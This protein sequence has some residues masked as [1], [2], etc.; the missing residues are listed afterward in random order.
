MDAL[1]SSLISSCGMNCGICY[2]Y[3]REKNKCQ[4]CRFPDPHKPIT[5]VKCKIKNCEGIKYSKRTFCFECN[6]FPCDVLKHLDKRYRTKYNMSMI[7]NLENI[8]NLGVKKFI[9]NEQIRWTCPE[10]KGTICVH[11]KQCY[12]GRKV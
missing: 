11:N 1:D 2:A 9:Q 3:L 7:E 8:K 5:R 4:G 10:C 6:E 12:G